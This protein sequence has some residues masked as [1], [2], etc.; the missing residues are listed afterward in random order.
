[1]SHRDINMTVKEGLFRPLRAEKPV[2]TLHLLK[3][4]AFTHKKTPLKELTR[5]FLHEENRKARLAVLKYSCEIGEVMY[6]ATC[7]RIEFIFTTQHSC[8]QD[9][10]NKF[11]HHFREDWNKSEIEFAIKHAEVFEG[12]EALRHIYRVASSLDSLVVGEREI[13]AQVRK[14]Y[15][16]C[17]AD[18][19][20]G[21]VLRLV[22]KT[23]VTT[24]K[25]IY[26][27][28][29]IASNPISVVSLAERKLREY[30]LDKISRIVLIG[31]GETNTNL[32][33]YLVKQGFCNFVV[34]N[35]TVENAQKLCK[36]I[37]SATVTAVAHPLSHILKY[38]S[39]LDVLVTCTATDERLIT[40]SVYTSLL[41]GETDKKVIVDLSV[42][43]N[44]DPA[45]LALPYVQLIDIN[46]LKS[47]AESNLVERQKE[48]SAAEILIEANILAFHQ[49][50]RTRSLE[51]K[52]KNVPEKIREIKDKAVN[53]VFANEISHLDEASR[54]TLLKVLDYMEKKYISVPMVMAKEII[55]ESTN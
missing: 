46:E 53:D 21:D 24:A 39:G 28:T 34:F 29:K 55:I 38:Q 23:T 1:M 10:L 44:V 54:E 45:V 47:I 48:F 49:M 32:A 12:D 5:F 20:T 40:P 35:R 37:S 41:N 52:L 6:V 33:K 26:T 4:I 7:N 31:S 9:F 50:H 36:I 19:L 14:A 11:F 8:D 43:S 16:A 13:I 2:S 51:L 18:G 27:E 17:C 3:T 15:D 22:V 30:K 25:Q 42:P